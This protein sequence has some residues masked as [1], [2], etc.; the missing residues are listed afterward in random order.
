MF[1]DSTKILQVFEY[2]FILI[3]ILKQFY[4]E[5]FL[6]IKCITIIVLKFRITHYVIHIAHHT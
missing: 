5:L 6:K 2:L 1:Q 4:L 3:K